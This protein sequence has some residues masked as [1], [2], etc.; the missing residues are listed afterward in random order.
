MTTLRG[1]LSSPDL[2]IGFAIGGVLAS[3]LGVYATR[4]IDRTAARGLA[5]L[6]RRSEL[7]RASEQEQAEFLA[8][9]RD[10]SLVHPIMMMQMLVL[11]AVVATQS[12]SFAILLWVLLHLESSFFPG[13]SLQWFL[14]ILPFS[15]AVA[16]WII[17]RATRQQFRIIR[18]AT[19]LRSGENHEV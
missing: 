14:M 9:D 18:A 16:G 7:Q 3:I 1:R 6:R 19:A 10:A 2:W 11:Y 5:R 17:L 8:Q 12:V 4:V 15:M 13:T